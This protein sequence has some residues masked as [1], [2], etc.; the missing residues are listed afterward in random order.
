MLHYARC[1]THYLLYVADLL[2]AELRAAGERVPSGW[3][4]PVPPHSGAA[5]R[6]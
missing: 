1:D 4:V 2:K 3:A 6:S 5:V